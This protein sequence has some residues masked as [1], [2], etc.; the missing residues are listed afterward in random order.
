MFKKIEKIR[1]TTL[2]LI[3]I[4]QMLLEINIIIYFLSIRLKILIH[5]YKYLF[6]YFHYFNRFCIKKNIKFRQRQNHY[7]IAK[8]LK[9]IFD[10]MA[11][12]NLSQNLIANVYN[13]IYISL[14]HLMPLFT[15][16]QTN[17]LKCLFLETTI[18]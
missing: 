12:N 8:I 3:K 2:C 1:K 10:C 15:L 18:L 17:Y 6:R 4:I 9:M 14:S 5:V 7:K 16:E 13:D 11:L